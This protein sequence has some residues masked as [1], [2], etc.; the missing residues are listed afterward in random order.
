MRGFLIP[1]A[2]GPHGRGRPARCRRLAGVALFILLAQPAPGGD[3]DAPPADLPS[4]DVLTRVPS[5][6]LALAIDRSTAYLMRHCAT[7][8]RFDYIRYIDG[9][10]PPADA[11]NLLRHAGSMYALAMAHQRKPDAGVRAALARAAAY[12]ARHMAPGPGHPPAL[13]L[14]S[15]GPRLGRASAP[16]LPVAK[17]GGAGLGLVAFCSLPP[18]VER[19]GLEQL[20]GL[21]RFILAMQREDGGFHS[22]YYKGIG[23]D[24]MW[25]SLYYPGEAM[26]GLVCLHDID[27]DPRWLTCA[28]RAMEYLLRERS[29]DKPPPP[30]HWALLATERLLPKIDQIKTPRLQAEPIHSHAAR[31]CEVMIAQQNLRPELPAVHGSFLSEGRTCPTAIRLEGL[32]AA[33]C[34]LPQARDDLRRRI[35]KAVH[36]GVSFLVRTQVKRGELAGGIARSAVRLPDRPEHSAFNKRVAEIRIDYVQHALSAMIAYER[37]FVQHAASTAP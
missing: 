10:P 3:A 8:G 13:A 33:L 28:A 18:E 31:I 7:S 26:L 27:Q 19:P 15:P 37:A 4:P 36:L 23:P 14:W 6:Q 11:Y 32:L 29:R 1:Q 16:R 25:H 30:D 24:K 17:L 9:R 21:A 20:I 34:F 35:E 5:E 2:V 12:L 22:R